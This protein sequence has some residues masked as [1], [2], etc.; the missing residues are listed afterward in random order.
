[1]NLIL[2]V[3]TAINDAV[4]RHLT[5]KFCVVMKYCSNVYIWDLK[6]ESKVKN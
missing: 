2:V 6:D 3:L 4:F 1:M 5:I